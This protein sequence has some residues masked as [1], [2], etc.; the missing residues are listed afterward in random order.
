MSSSSLHSEDHLVGILALAQGEQRLHILAE[1]LNLA[2]LVER[3]SK[4]E[5]KN[6]CVGC[7]ATLTGTI[8]AC[9]ASETGVAIAACIA[10]VVGA[11][12]A[13]Y[14]C[15]CWAIEQVLGRQDWFC[16]WCDC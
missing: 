10:G 5:E 3:I 9:A 11:G 12:N 14:P 8:L 7:L 13:C 4:G 16:D 2:N 6:D 1:M 15:I